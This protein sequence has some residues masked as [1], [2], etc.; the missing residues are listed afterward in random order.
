MYDEADNQDIGAIDDAIG[1]IAARLEMPYAPRVR[2]TSSPA[3]GT[4][5]VHVARIVHGHGS[6]IRVALSDEGLEAQ[7]AAYCRES[8]SEVS[9]QKGVPSD[10]AGMTDHE[11]VTTYY[12]AMER[13]EAED[14]LDEQTFEVPVDAVR[15]ASGDCARCGSKL[16]AIGRCGD[17]TCPFSDTVQSDAQGWAGHPQRDPEPTEDAAPVPTGR[18]GAFDDAAAIA[19]E[20]EERATADIWYD[21]HEHGDPGDDEDPDRIAESSIERTQ[22]AMLE[23]A[24]I[25]RYLQPVVLPDGAIVIDGRI[26]SKTAI[27][28]RARKD[29]SDDIRYITYQDGESGDA[30]ITMAATMG[31]P[32]ANG[33]DDSIPLTDREYEWLGIGEKLNVNGDLTVSLGASAIWHRRKWLVAEIEFAFADQGDDTNDD[34]VALRAANHHMEHIAP[35]VDA[36]GGLM[37]LDEDATEFG[38]ELAIL[39]P[40]EIAMESASWDDWTRALAYL[41][42]TE[43][44]KKAGPRVTAEYTAQQETGRG[45]YSVEPS[46]DTVWDATF[47]ALRWG[48][49]HADDIYNGTASYPDDYAHSVMAPE[50]VRARSAVHPFEVQA[51]GLGTF[52]GIEGSD[53]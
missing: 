49:K 17:E 25:L 45:V 40:F 31:L 46:G 44:E 8:W 24:R 18:V 37:V 28:D 29:A 23:A 20:L 39:I 43:R 53:D 51:I 50:W 4:I 6:D 5:T 52:Y 16:N 11:V 33:R 3:P 42:S 10:P 2:T 27:A 35:Y 13:S 22:N 48:R 38:H 41:L 47:D 14:F 19:T 34:G 15:S 36:I 9:D 1:S 26:Q 7:V 30:T 21:A 12:A 32:Y